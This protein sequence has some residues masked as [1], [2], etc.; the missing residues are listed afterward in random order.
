MTR[1]G[2]SM[3]QS[4][5]VA[6]DLG[7]E[8]GCRHVMAFLLPAGEVLIASSDRNLP[9]PADSGVPA[10]RQH[11]GVVWIVQEATMFLLVRSM[12]LAS[13]LAFAAAT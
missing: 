2:R 13:L 6:G 1:Q 8:V 10:H 9:L 5:P 7:R 11:F 4:S 3:P 12:V